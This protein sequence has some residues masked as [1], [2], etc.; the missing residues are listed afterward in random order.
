MGRPARNHG[1][2]G[3]HGCLPLPG[4]RPNYSHHV[5]KDKTLQTLVP[6]TNQKSG[7][8]TKLEIVAHL[9]KSREKRVN[10]DRPYD[11]VSSIEP[12]RVNVDT[13]ELMLSARRSLTVTRKVI[14]FLGKSSVTDPMILSASRSLPRNVTSKMM[15]SGSRILGTFRIKGQVIPLAS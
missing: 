9:P 10:S 4:E 11:S 8:T 15:L 6:H 5:L 1:G 13:Q 3:G 12:K 2:T 14:L 7:R